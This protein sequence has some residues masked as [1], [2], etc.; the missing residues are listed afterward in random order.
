M[1]LKNTETLTVFRIFE[2]ICINIIELF[3]GN[4]KATQSENGVRGL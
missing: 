4:V 1:K 2:V 3:F